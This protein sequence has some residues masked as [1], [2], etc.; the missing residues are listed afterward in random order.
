MYRVSWPNRITIARILLVG[1]FVV[2]LLHL[3]DAVWHE[4]ARYW[5]LLTFAL[6][7]ISDGLDGYLA[8]R[9]HEE[10]A[11][12]RFLDPLADKLL[13]FCSVI[14]LAHPSTQV[15]GIRLPSTAA[16]IAVGKDVIVVLGF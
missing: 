14:L 15:P 16:V 2:A 10:S 9:L 11:V 4:W 1:P 3:Q 5:A 12:G 13:I 6:M 7:A 8:R